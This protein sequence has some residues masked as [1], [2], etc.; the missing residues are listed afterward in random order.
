MATATPIASPPDARAGPGNL[1]DHLPKRRPQARSYE[2]PSRVGAHLSYVHWQLKRFLCGLLELSFGLREGRTR[3]RCGRPF[4]NE[5][6][7]FFSNTADGQLVYS[8]PPGRARSHRRQLSLEPW[9]I[10]RSLPAA[11]STK[12][13]RWR[14]CTRHRQLH[15]AGLEPVLHGLLLKA[16]RA[17]KDV[18]RRSATERRAAVGDRRRRMV[19]PLSFGKRVIGPD[20]DRHRAIPLSLVPHC[21]RDAPDKIC[22]EPFGEVVNGREHVA[23]TLAGRRQLPHSA[24]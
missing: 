8:T 13:C 24:G 9:G 18:R 22:Y 10:T 1:A 17:F 2:E 5:E 20:G 11:R 15:R 16:R 21:G 14:R 7:P 3:A 4:V 19:G 6:P 12:R 23:A